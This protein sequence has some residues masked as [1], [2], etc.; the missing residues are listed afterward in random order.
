MPNQIQVTAN[1]SINVSTFVMMDVST[2]DRVIAA[3]GSSG[4][5][6]GVAQEFGNTPPTPGATSTVA[7]TAGQPIMVYT[8]GDVCYLQAASA[9]WTAGD[10]LCADSNAN[11]VK[12]G[13][14]NWFG[15]R[16]LATVTSGA[17]GIVQV[18]F[19]KA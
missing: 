7:A 6:V 2:S 8:I 17:L 12:A 11:A 1:G 10:L 14:G 16:A 19:G 15:A 9:G 18:A 3:T 4:V 5:I 13:T